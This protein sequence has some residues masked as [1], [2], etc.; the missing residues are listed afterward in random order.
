[1]YAKMLK[2]L[3]FTLIIVAV[4][5]AFLAIR[6]LFRKNGRFPDTHAGHS[7]AM[8]RRGITCV[9]AMD[10]LERAGNPHRIEERSTRKP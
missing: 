9:Q 2:T 5:V 10:A 7:A 6:I 3:S 1:M 4:S 8:R